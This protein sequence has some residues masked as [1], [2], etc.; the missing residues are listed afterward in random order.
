MARRERIFCALLGFLIF[1]L[2]AGLAEAH[3]GGLSNIELEVKESSVDATITVLRYDF[4]YLVRDILTGMPE[5]PADEVLAQQDKIFAYMPTRL[6]LTNGDDPL[7]FEPVSTEIFEK[8]GDLIVK[9]R[10]VSQAPLSELK[11]DCTL[12]QEPDPRHQNML[13]INAPN[14]WDLVVLRNDQDTTHSLS[15]AK[16]SVWAR[17]SDFLL[18]YIGAF[19]LGAIHAL[20]PGHGKTLVGAYLVG[21]RGRLK[22][23]VILGGI[24]TLT[25]T[26][27][28]FVLGLIM[29]AASAVLLPAQVQMWA[30]MLSGVLVLGVGFWLIYQRIYLPLRAR[31]LTAPNLHHNGHDHDHNHGHLH[32]YDHGHDHDHS[33]GHGHAHDHSHDHDHDHSH[34]HDHDHSHGHSHVA[35]SESHKRAHLLGLPHSHAIPAAGAI[36]LGTLLTLGISGGI[37]PC[38]EALVALLM[39]TGSG[40]AVSGIVFVF[41]FSLGLASVLI[42]LGI[43]MVK[44]GQVVQRRFKGG[45]TQQL[46]F[47]AGAFSA[48]LITVIGG[49]MCLKYGKMLLA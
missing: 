6:R 38:P 42:A 12:F 31:R 26:G 23:A 7:T 25:H 43:M 49:Y 15:L 17:F 2:P 5:V 37:V 33:H 39:A 46:A 41:V 36:T 8:T 9:G 1:V 10:Y 20:T 34:D 29:L 19:S 27:G 22:D 28:I 44:A 13:T 16:G 30:S 11:I 4:G 24:V 47:G 48:V 45:R 35:E 40:K 14:K 18:F 32:D 21:S 3:I